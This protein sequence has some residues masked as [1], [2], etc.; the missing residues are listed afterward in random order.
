M[1]RTVTLLATTLVVAAGITSTASAATLYTNAAHTA[2][3][4][5][6]TSITASGHNYQIYQGGGGLLDICATNILA[7]KVTQNSGGIFNATITNRSLSGCANNWG[8]GQAGNLKISGSSIAVGAT[9]AWRTTTLTGTLQLYSN[10]YTENFVSATGN[11]PV[12]GVFAQ[13]PTSGASP[14]TITLNNAGSITGPGL[15]GTVTGSY[16]LSGSYS[17]G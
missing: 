3:V 10:V 4:A 13:Q 1:R 17:L 15:N 9:S 8:V 2:P 11:P 6:G 7:F 12:N 14:V 5:V 16:V